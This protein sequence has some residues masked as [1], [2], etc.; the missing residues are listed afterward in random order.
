MQP[1]SFI[2]RSIAERGRL[3]AITLLTAITI[4]V[5]LLLTAFA[6]NVAYM[7]MIREQLRVACDSSAKAALVNYGAS[8][9]KTT[10]ISFAQTIANASQRFGVDAAIHGDL[11]AAESFHPVAN[12]G[13]H[14]HQSRHHP[15]LGPFSVNGLRFERQRV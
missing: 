7:Q 4:P 6:V 13:R 3:G 2:H 1:I 14:S 5:L 11:L 15:G 8:Q 9:N 10:A 12:F